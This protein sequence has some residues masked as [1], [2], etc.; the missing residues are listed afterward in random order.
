MN[1]DATHF[2]GICYLHLIKLLFVFHHLISH[3]ITSTSHRIASH[4]LC[5]KLFFDVCLCGMS[6]NCKCET[7]IQGNGEIAN[8]A[9]TFVLGYRNERASESDRDTGYEKWNDG[10]LICL[11]IS[12]IIYQ[13]ENCEKL[14][15]SICR[16]YTTENFSASRFRSFST[17]IQKN[18]RKNRYINER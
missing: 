18:R 12:L 11:P 7:H 8:R 17:K 4:L 10:I 1:V 2:D 3:H 14:I 5:N 15:V 16:S 13:R 9:L 6:S